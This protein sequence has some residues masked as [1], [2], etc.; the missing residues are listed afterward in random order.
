MMRAARRPYVRDTMM[1]LC[2][3]ASLA[4]ALFVS[5]TATATEPV[6][7]FRSSEIA[8]AAAGEILVTGEPGDVNRG[9]V[10]GMLN[11]PIDEIVAIIQDVDNHEHWFPDT[12]N[13]TLLSQDGATATFSGE[14]HVPILPDRRWTNR[15]T[16]RTHNF[17]TGECHVFEY[18][19]VEDSGNMD[20]LH[21]YWL[22]CPYEEDASKTMLKYVINADLG[23]PL[24]NSL[25]NWAS[26]R[27][28]PGV[29]EGLQAR[30]DELY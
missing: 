12:D 16:H 13:T 21:G 28:L 29:I 20:V 9:V 3:A 8:E 10:I 24:P 18:E 27:M 26:R 15:G 5:A 2:T 4:A 14:T 1:R 22:L 11:A 19:Y 17:T 23:V 7:P 25:I 6:T 30:H